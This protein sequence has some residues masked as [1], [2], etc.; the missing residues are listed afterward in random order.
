MQLLAAA[1]P[2]A[3]QR[4]PGCEC[5][6]KEQVTHR[7]VLFIGVVFVLRRIPEVARA[8]PKVEVYIR[9]AIAGGAEGLTTIAAAGVGGNPDLIHL[10]NRGAIWD[11]GARTLRVGP[12]EVRC[13]RTL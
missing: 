5:R 2:S 13:A 10:D 11:L 9:G 1:A 7:V 8:V 12:S 6:L 4:T 3:T